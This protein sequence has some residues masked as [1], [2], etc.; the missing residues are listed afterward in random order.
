MLDSVLEVAALVGIIS[1]DGAVVLLTTVGSI[2]K[3]KAD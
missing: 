3:G 2:V 1:N